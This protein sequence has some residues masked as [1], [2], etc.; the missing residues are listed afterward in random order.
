M[1]FPALST[2]VKD[3]QG[4]TPQPDHSR[5]SQSV[6]VLTTLVICGNILFV[7]K[8]DVKFQLLKNYIFYVFWF[9]RQ[10]F[11]MQQL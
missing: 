8:G 4:Q 5:F 7:R 9:L 3:R 2:S 10:V 6:H 11:S 1:T